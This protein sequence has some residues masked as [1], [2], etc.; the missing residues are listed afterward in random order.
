MNQY[1]QYIP[2]DQELHEAFE[3]HKK[4]FNKFYLEKASQD[5]NKMLLEDLNKTFI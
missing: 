5:I 1:L 2:D 3:H 4:E